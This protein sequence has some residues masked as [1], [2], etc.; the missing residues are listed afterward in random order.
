MRLK[1]NQTTLLITQALACLA[2]TGCGGSNGDSDLPDDAA[3]VQADPEREQAERV[4]WRTIDKIAPNIA[5]TGRSDE[6]TTVIRLSG[7]VTDNLRLYKVRWT[8]SRGGQGSATLTGSATEA[9]WA[10]SAIQLQAGDNA[11]T[12]TAQDWAGNTAQ[13]TTTVNLAAPS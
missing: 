3:Q 6:S 1:L 13:A 10:T 2:I 12:V 4:R 7:K 5:I 8:N 9:A 11:I